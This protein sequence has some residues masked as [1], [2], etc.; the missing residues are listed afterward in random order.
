MVVVVVWYL[1]WL[2]HSGGGGVCGMSPFNGGSFNSCSSA[3]VKCPIHGEVGYKNVDEG[4]GGGDDGGGVSG[5]DHGGQERDH[6][7]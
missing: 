1:W 7:N 3:I 6:N 5:G 4:G 2:L